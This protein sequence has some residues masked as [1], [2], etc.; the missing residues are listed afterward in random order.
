MVQHTGGK[1]QIHGTKQR[2]DNQ[3]QSLEI[4]CRILSSECKHDIKESEGNMFNPIFQENIQRWKY[5]GSWI[6]AEPEFKS[7]RRRKPKRVF[8]N[9][10]NGHKNRNNSHNYHDRKHDEIELYQG[11]SKA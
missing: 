1:W 2:K 8:Q 5:T 11:N 7:F 6:F 3:L 4:C 10:K 9:E